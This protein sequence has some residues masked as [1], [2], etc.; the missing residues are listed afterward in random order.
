MGLMMFCRGSQNVRL[1]TETDED[2]P[3]M[4]SRLGPLQ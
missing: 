1:G 3:D 4:D 2:Q